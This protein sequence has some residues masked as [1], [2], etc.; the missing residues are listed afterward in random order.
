MR[1]K[2]RGAKP[3]IT[4]L[5]QT[6]Y[7]RAPWLYSFCYRYRLFLITFYHWLLYDWETLTMKSVVNI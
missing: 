6:L 3:R 1:N 2:T 7:H 4:T 5:N